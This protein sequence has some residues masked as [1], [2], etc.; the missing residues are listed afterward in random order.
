MISRR[1][2]LKL[3]ALSMF[4]LIGGA[5]LRYVV[6]EAGILQIPCCP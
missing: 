4:I 1:N 5:M 3:A 2:F 6:L